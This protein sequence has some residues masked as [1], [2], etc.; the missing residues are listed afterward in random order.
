MNEKIFLDSSVEHIKPSLQSL[1][2]DVTIDPKDIKYAT[3]AIYMADGYNTNF[4]GTFSNM[5]SGID[6]NNNS[7]TFLINAKEKSLDD[8]LFMIK[9]RCYSSLF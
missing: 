5:T 9:N 7:H 1:G 4:H 2:Y 6:M 8:I 3:V